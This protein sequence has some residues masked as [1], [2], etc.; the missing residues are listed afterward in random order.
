MVLTIWNLKYIP[1]QNFD[2]LMGPVMGPEV[3]VWTIK[4]VNF[5]RMSA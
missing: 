1:K 3:K 5:I 4:N 2:P